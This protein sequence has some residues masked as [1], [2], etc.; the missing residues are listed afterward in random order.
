VKNCAGAEAKWEI[1]LMEFTRRR[2]KPLRFVRIP[3][4][5]DHPDWIDLNLQLDQDHL[6]RRIAALVEG[7]DLFPL[8]ETYS[9]VGAAILPPELMLAFVLFEIQRGR[10]SPA[11]W[12]QDSQDQSLPA[13]WLLRG[14]LP[15]RS[16]FYRFRSH[17]PPHLVDLLNSQVLLLAVAEG[18][19]TASQAALDGTF[20]AAHGSRHRLLNDETL[21]KRLKCLEEA[22]ALDDPGVAATPLDACPARQTPPATAAGAASVAPAAPPLPLPHP[23]DASNQATAAA[24]TQLL[25]PA[26]PYWMAP[27]KS[28]RR[29]QR[30][31]YHRAQKILKT[32]LIDHEKKQKGKPIAKRKSADKVV[33]CPMEPEAVL[34]KD[35]LK[36][37][38]PLY[39]TQIAQ[40]LDSPFVLSYGVYAQATDSGLLPPMAERT[41]KLTGQKLKK[42]LSD[43]IYATLSGVRYCKEN[44]VELY[45]PVEADSSD[46][47]KAG[48][49]AGEAAAAR[50]K[51]GRGKKQEKKFGKEQFH[52]EEEQRAYRCPEGHLLQLGV[53][54]NREREQG[55]VVVSEEYRCDKKHCMKCPQAQRC[56]SRPDRGRTVERMQGQELLDEVAARMKTE[57]GKKEYKK[58][59]QT[60][61]PRHADMRQHRGL[62]QFH[63]YGQSQAHSQVGLLVLAHN[64]LSLFQCR[65]KRQAMP[66]ARE[67]PQ[68]RP[69]LPAPE[70]LP[71]V[72]PARER[73]RAAPPLPAPERLPARPPA[74]ERRQA[75]PPAPVP[76]R[77]KTRRY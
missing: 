38:R 8:F 54:R 10:L 14:L 64:G 22:I 25:T 45:A 62:Q 19:T 11:E 29:C 72:P 71:A 63:G 13:R 75:K 18:H 23:S 58:R 24:G 28:G 30:E 69:P 48:G 16:A 26:Q 77:L 50:A 40:D 31:R 60:V 57:E 4:S 73:L 68:G 59:K 65:K 51:S 36:V 9:G 33:I 21:S 2:S 32:W 7:L 76:E 34:G 17:L 47:S 27:T 70:R 35:K 6:A 5:D 61:E 3:W 67:R 53:I 20:T 46:K 15:S 42:I 12:F 44:G 39:N 49:G 41:Q 74:P 66:P 43:G 52:W 55:E 1:G 56:T 37:F